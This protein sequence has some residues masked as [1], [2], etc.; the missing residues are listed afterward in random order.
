MQENDRLALGELRR[1]LNE[2]NALATRGNSKVILGG[3]IVVKYL[4]PEIPRTLRGHGASLQLEIVEMLR[5]PLLAALMNGEVDIAVCSADDSHVHG[6]VQL[7]LLED[8]MTV[9]AHRGHP[10]FASSQ[11]LDLGSLA[12]YP[13]ILPR[14]DEIERHQLELAFLNAGLA[15]PDVRIE[16]TSV[17]V[18]ASII[19]MDEGL[20]YLPRRA[21]LM[22]RTLHELRP[23]PVSLP[24]RPRRVSLFHR[25]S[26]LDLDHIHWV[27]EAIQGVARQSA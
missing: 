2:V 23:V 1:S 20:S 24:W 16:T 7:P 11:A 14:A 21:L 9:V 25:E 5:A 19:G 17:S 15:R 8:E 6:R 27:V 26:S 4:L 3:G 12:P 13:W 22:D 10:L 18:M